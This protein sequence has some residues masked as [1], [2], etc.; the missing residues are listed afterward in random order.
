ML[1]ICNLSAK[2][3]ISNWRPFKAGVLLKK[4]F[5]VFNTKLQ[6]TTGE[7]A[8]PQPDFE[9]VESFYED[10]YF[11]PALEAVTNEMKS[12]FPPES[13][14]TLIALSDVIN[15]ESPSEDNI[16]EAAR[17]CQVDKDLILPERN[18][19]KNMKFEENP[20]NNSCQLSDF[21]AVFEKQDL[22][23]LLPN[24][25]SVLRNLGVKPVTSCT[26]ERSFSSMRIILNHMRATMGE[27]RFDDI[28]VMYCNR[29]ISND[30]LRNDI[31]EIINEF[32]KHGD[33]KKHLI[34]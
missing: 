32:A 21:F 5:H 4:R 10:K 33:R 20:L 26:A 23:Q 14:K 11:R 28:A 19:L 2:C 9:N 29:D 24:F 1:T 25:G 13:Q 17:F 6:G 34:A 22:F 30:V 16:S 31:D 15:S 18:I 8:T 3:L 7:V 27:S 12:R